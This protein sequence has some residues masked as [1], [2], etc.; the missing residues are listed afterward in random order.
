ML[1]KMRFRWIPGCCHD[2]G[3]TLWLVPNHMKKIMSLT[4]PTSP[5]PCQKISHLTPR[6]LYYTSKAINNST[7][8]GEFAALSAY[9]AGPRI[10]TYARRW[11]VHKI[12]QP[13]V[14]IP[15]SSRACLVAER[16]IHHLYQDHLLCNHFWHP[17]K[18]IRY[19]VTNLIPKQATVTSALLIFLFYR[20]SRKKMSL[21]SKVI[22]ASWY[23]KHP[24]GDDDGNDG[25]DYAPAACIEGNG[26]DDDGDYD[27][28][29]AAS[30]DCDDDDDDD[31]SYDYAPAA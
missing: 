18:N 24:D 2:D 7:N 20:S 26:D 11:V 8:A 29:P 1:R 5:P 12:A 16:A 25:Y 13:L 3:T 19:G 9:V 6:C 28:T 30:L 21:L 14:F 15:H 4:F 31:G 17:F 23:K 22:V 10:A 27:C